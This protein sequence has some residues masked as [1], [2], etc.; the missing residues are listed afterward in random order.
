M[1]CNSS[2]PKRADG[3]KPRASALRAPPWVL[4]SHKFCPERANGR[5]RCAVKRLLPPFQG[6]VPSRS[7]NPGRRS[8]RACPGLVPVRPLRGEGWMPSRE[9]TSLDRTALDSRR[10]ASP[11][12]LT[13]VRPARRQIRPP[14]NRCSPSGSRADRLAL[15]VQLFRPEAGGWIQ[16]QGKLAASA[17]LGLAIAQ[18]LP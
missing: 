15:G 14:M 12:R 3:Y 10:D 6:G 4:P 9:R 16:A 8:K 13:I 7:T 1:A 17:A 11:S 2:A 18:I 5:H